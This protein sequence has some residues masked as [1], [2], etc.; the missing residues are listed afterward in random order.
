MAVL[1]VPGFMLDADLWRDVAPELQSCGPILHADTSRDGS[2]ADM[3][4]RALEDA[5]GSFV[6]IGFSMGGY[7]ARE[8]ARL[9][10]DRVQALILIATSARGDTGVQ[11]QRKAALAAQ[12]PSMVF[13][14]L[15]KPAVISSLHPDRAADADLIARIQAM[16][17]RLG[18]EVFRRQSL[19]ARHDERDGLGA[20]HCPTL[21]IAGPQDRLR[22]LDEARELHDGIP[23]SDFSVIEG[24]GHMIPLEAPERMAALIAKWLAQKGFGSPQG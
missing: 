13:A 22:S 11:A 10:P 8:I 6:L 20:I 9:A 18:G 2:I 12:T 19:L 3:A 7:V 16:G 23:G 21:V 5:S 17:A 15:S 1:C 4:R 24:A 14:G